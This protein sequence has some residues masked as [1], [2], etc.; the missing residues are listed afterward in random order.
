VEPETELSAECS[1]QLCPIRWVQRHESV[2]AVMEAISGWND[3]AIML[4]IR[5]IQ[6]INLDPAPVIELTENVEFVLSEIQRNID[7]R[8]YMP[9]LV[10]LRRCVMNRR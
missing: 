10:M 2:L 6:I 8:S 1:K 4:F 3:N 5:L 9:F 7:T